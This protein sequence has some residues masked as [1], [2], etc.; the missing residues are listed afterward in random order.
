[1]RSSASSHTLSY[2]TKERLYPGGPE[3]LSLNCKLLLNLLHAT[4]GD[5]TEPS[6]TVGRKR[7]SAF[8]HT[9]SRKRRDLGTEEIGASYPPN[10]SIPVLRHEFNLQYSKQCQDVRPYAQLISDNNAEE[11]GLTSSEHALVVFLSNSCA[12]QTEPIT[13]DCGD[14]LINSYGKY[15]GTIDAKPSHLEEQWADLYNILFVPALH[16]EGMETG[17]GHLFSWVDAY[18]RSTAPQS[19]VE[20]TACLRMVVFPLT[21]WDETLHTLPFRLVVD[22]VLSFLTPTIF[23]PSAN[24]RNGLNRSEIEKAR[25][26]LLHLA[27]P[28]PLLPETLSPSFQGRIDVPF[29]YS[30][31]QPARA[32]L[33]DSVEKLLQPQ[34]LLPR[35]LPFQRRTVDWMLAREGKAFGPS[36]ELASMVTEPVELSLLW[37]PVTVRRD[38]EQLTWYYRRLTGALTPERPNPQIVLGGILAEEPGLGKT[39]ECIALILLNPGIGRSLSHAR[40]D[41]E[42]RM[43]RT[44]IQVCPFISLSLRNLC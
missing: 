32:V 28:P 24:H 27:F 12:S 10:E 7:P 36:G 3:C 16:T 40:W 17:D 41:P 34:D 26:G 37:Q 15:G 20:V 9:F 5:N 42:A 1:M 13:L 18:S 14:V 8:S 19:A 6:T 21:S 44:E 35:L 22:V 31:V 30:V 43:T 38:G 2:R 33:H 4:L 39:V 23:W 29:L 25:R 11:D